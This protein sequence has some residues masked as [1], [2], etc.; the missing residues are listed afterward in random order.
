VRVK[1]A[2]A[3]RPI[4]SVRPQPGSYRRAATSAS[5]TGFDGRS[6][7]RPDR[8]AIAHEAFVP[9]PEGVEGVP[10][11]LEA[12][13]MSEEAGRGGIGRDGRLVGVARAR[14]AAGVAHRASLADKEGGRA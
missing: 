10:A 3:R 11:S 8:V 13:R 14:P 9:T 7:A 2:G 5:V 12:Y 6:T 1:G 4:G